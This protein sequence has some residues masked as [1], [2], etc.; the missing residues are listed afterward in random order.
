MTGRMGVCIVSR[1]KAPSVPV[2]CALILSQGAKGAK[3]LP[4][5]V[6]CCAVLRVVASGRWAPVH[7]LPGCLGA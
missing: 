3:A 1:R 4:A 6:L 7:V 5:P 2:C